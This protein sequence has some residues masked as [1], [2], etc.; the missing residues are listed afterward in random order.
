M[1]KIIVSENS[2]VVLCSHR[3]LPPTEIVQDCLEKAK[4]MLLMATGGAEIAS[5]PAE[6]QHQYLC[7]LDDLVEL[8]MDQFSQCRTDYKT[9]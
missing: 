4:S 7:L 3:G 9:S 1:A 8:A 5:L 6:A 2:D